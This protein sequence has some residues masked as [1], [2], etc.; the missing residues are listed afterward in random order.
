[1]SPRLLA[2]S[3]LAACA[4]LPHACATT[5]PRSPHDAATKIA[6][7]TA[8]VTQQEARP[9]TRRS[10]GVA[11]AFAVHIAA[12]GLKSDRTGLMSGAREPLSV[13]LSPR[14]E[15]A[16][17]AAS[18]TAVV[19]AAPLD[20]DARAAL[21]RVALAE[22]RWSERDHAAMWHVLQRFASRFGLTLQAA[23]RLRVE[24][25]SRRPPRWITRVESSCVEPIGW[26]ASLSWGRHSDS[27][28]AL[29]ARVDAFLRGLLEDPCAGRALGWR[30]PAALPEAL[31]RGRRQVWCGPTANRFVR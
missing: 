1:M 8:P 30:S 22:A 5:S 6:N 4:V 9:P 28:W 21:V 23:I 15:S 20:S 16:S 26:P 14:A 7:T 18:S 25:F 31:A 24:R 3:W 12:R 10:N 13:A 11:G 29:Y 27:C 2:Y 19:G 17:T